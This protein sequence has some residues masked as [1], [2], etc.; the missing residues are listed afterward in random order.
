MK[1]KKLLFLLA[2]LLIVILVFLF[3]IIKNFNTGSENELSSDNSYPMDYTP[4]EEISPSDVRE[5]V[6]T[7]YFLDPSTLEIK[8]EGRLI[9]SILLLDNPY[10]TLVEMLLSN[11]ESQNLEKVFP[12]GTKLLDS[13]LDVNCVTLN[14]SKEFLN[15]K[16]DTQKFYIINSLINTLSEL[17]EVNSIKILVEN[18]VPENF[19]EIYPSKYNT[20]K[21]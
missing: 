18:S 12:D 4:E 21:Q 1:N 19:E 6:V 17:N 3:F 13:S 8:S 14:F 9:D 5:T 20:Q 7:L 10:K 11:P 16:D 15:F 2:T